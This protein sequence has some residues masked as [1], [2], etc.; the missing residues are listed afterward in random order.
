[1]Q[2]GNFTNGQVNIVTVQ[3]DEPKKAEP[4]AEPESGFNWWILGGSL[5]GLL[6]LGSALWYFLAKRKEKEEE[7]EPEVIEEIAATED[8]MEYQEK[9]EVPETTE[10]SLDDQVHQVTREH[11]EGTAKVIKKWLNGQ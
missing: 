3:F 6:L 9:I 1:D 2:S 11:T 8:I 7:F 4:K 10:P 5:V